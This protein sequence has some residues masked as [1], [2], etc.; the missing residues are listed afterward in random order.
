[1]YIQCILNNP[2]MFMSRWMENFLL[3]IR[4]FDPAP[5]ILALITL[6]SSEGS[7]AVILKVLMKMK[8]PVGYVITGV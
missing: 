5:E 4:S 6:A 3:V 2:H 8:S 1:M 7:D